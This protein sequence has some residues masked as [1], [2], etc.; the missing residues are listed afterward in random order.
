LPYSNGDGF[1]QG[2]HH[3]EEHE[4]TVD[5]NVHDPP[6]KILSQYSV[7]KHHIKNKDLH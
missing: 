2:M 7:L 1:V 5:K 4:A 6:E 3:E